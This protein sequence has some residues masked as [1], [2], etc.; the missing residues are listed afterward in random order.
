MI[1]KSRNPPIEADVIA[2][3]RLGVAFPVTIT[4]NS[5]EGKSMTYGCGGEGGI[6]TQPLLLS[7]HVFSNMHQTSMNIGDF[8]GLA[9][10]NSFNPFA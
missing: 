3:N 5:R 10:F 4:T 8:Y 1:V 6:L 7:Y 9:L 2:V